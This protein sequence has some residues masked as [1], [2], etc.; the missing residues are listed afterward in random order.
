MLWSRNM[1]V[2][3]PA[4]VSRMRS[5]APRKRRYVMRAR[6][7]AVE[8]RKA[9]IVAA[10]LELFGAHDYDAVTLQMLADR[11]GVALKTIVR[12]FGTK[13]ALLVNVARQYEVEERK[14]RRAAVP[15]DTL[16]IARALGARYEELGNVTARMLTVES[17]IPAVAE[18]LRIARKSHLTW[19]ETMFAE[20]L[21][22][23]GP[24][25]ERRLAE[26]FGATE[27]FVWLSWR[28]HLGLGFH[29][30]EQ[31]MAEL[32]QALVARWNN[33]GDQA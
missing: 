10:A 30:A 19:L 21:P 23:S 9:R 1:G 28:R 18:V 25:R 4:A 2:G 26:L 17:R 12:Q 3:L 11:A 7:A 6:S 20:H 22:A 29:A 32:L 27:I 8:Q 5:A 14:V 16:S 31:A 33:Q 24:V 15:G 13:D